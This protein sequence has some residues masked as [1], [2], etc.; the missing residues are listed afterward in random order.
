MLAS[1]LSDTCGGFE[2]RVRS[3][4]SVKTKSFMF[5]SSETRRSRA[6]HEEGL[7]EEINRDTETTN[8]VQVKK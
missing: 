5:S 1:I 8:S 6:G 7:T 2:S 4:K 3:A